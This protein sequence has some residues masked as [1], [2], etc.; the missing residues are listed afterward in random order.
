MSEQKLKVLHLVDDFSM[1]GV[2]VALSSLTNSDLA[3]DYQFVI[4]RLSFDSVG[5]WL[6]AFKKIK[7]QNADMICIHYSANWW[8]LLFTG[9]LRMLFRG[10]IALQEHHY[11]RGFVQHNVKSPKRFY[12]MLKL[13]YRCVDQLLCISVSQRLWLLEQQ[14]VSDK[15]LRFV[16]QSCQRL[17]LLEL[18]PKPLAAP[19]VI[20]AYGR[21]NQQKGFDLLVQAM[22]LMDPQVVQLKLA[23]EGPQL[24]Q[25]QALA[26]ENDN[27]EFIGKVDDIGQFLDQVDM[28]AVPSRWEPFGL[29]CLESLLAGKPV[30]IS[31]A[32]GL[33]EQLDYLN[34]ANLLES[35]PRFTAMTP[36]AMAATLT[37]VLN[38]LDSQQQSIAL[39]DVARK[40]VAQSWPALIQRWR[41]VLADIKK[42]P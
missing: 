17:P 19:L 13:M 41:L 4:Q 12:R 9:L 10:R 14:L 3:K 8:R 40:R 15:K 26:D 5:Q 1:G 31:I 34:A 32:D 27:I 6:Q 33:P 36:V 2:N 25:L 16:G 23:G 7:Q 21:F 24:G 42:A 18:P 20:G 35:W 39:S 29:T 37:Q 30:I 28:V 11:S 38:Q 22:T